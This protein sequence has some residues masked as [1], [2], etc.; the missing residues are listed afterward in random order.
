MIRRPPRS[1]RPD[2]LFPYPTPFRSPGWLLKPPAAGLLAGRTGGI[3]IGLART[4]RSGPSRPR[5]RDGSRDWSFAGLP[6]DRLA[7][8]VR[9]PVVAGGL[10]DHVQHDPPEATL[11]PSGGTAGLPQGRF[12]PDAPPE[13]TPSRPPQPPP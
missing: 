6:V 5:W 9:V 2:S 7:A 1:T 10:L 3:G 12:P 4:A 11:P 13:A 8:Q